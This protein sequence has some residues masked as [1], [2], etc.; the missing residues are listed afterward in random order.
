M[1]PLLGLNDDLD[2]HS[3]GNKGSEIWLCAA[4]EKHRETTRLGRADC[5]RVFPFL[6]IYASIYVFMVMLC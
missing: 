2:K 6:R 5:V 3:S 1:I 4:L